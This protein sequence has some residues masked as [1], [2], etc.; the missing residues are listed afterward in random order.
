MSFFGDFGFGEDSGDYIVI[1]EV[2]NK[3]EMRLKCKNMKMFYQ[4][5]IIE[6]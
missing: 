5:W 6:S 4:V 1:E 3:H 2:T